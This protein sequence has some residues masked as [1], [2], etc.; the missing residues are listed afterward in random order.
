MT[1]PKV[2]APRRCGSRAGC[3][4]HNKQL[5][6]TGRVTGELENL[7]R[8][9]LEDGRHVHGGTTSDAGHVGAIAHVTR[10]TANRE[11]QA[12]FAAAGAALARLLAATTFTFACHVY[13]VV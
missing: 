9:V 13:K 3:D 8:Q 6:V 1:S 7:G 10:N 12:C 4:G 11:L 5:V 2:E